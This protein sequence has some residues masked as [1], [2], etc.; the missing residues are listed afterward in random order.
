MNY[1]ARRGKIY[2][3]FTQQLNK[4][5]RLLAVIHNWSFIHEEIKEL[6]DHSQKFRKNDNKVVESKNA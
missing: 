6:V 1:N 5:I 2:S 3:I 4:I